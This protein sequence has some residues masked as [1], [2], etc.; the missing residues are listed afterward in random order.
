M[1]EIKAGDVVNLKSGG[2]YMTAAEVVSVNEEPKE[3]IVIWSDERCADVLRD[4][5]PH[6]SLVKRD[7][8]A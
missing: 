4:I 8:L 2:P 7:N 1:S 3:V 6:C 5:L